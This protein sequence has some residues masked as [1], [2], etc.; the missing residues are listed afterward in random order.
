MISD[1]EQGTKANPSFTVELGSGISENNWNFISS[2]LFSYSFAVARS[3]ICVNFPTSS[4][5]DQ[6][7]S[8]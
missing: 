6:G 3:T 5:L 8:S 2:K 4:F 1:C 7:I